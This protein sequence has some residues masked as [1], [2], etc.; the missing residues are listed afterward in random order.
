MYLD[1]VI[2]KVARLGLVVYESKEGNLLNIVRPSSVAGSKFIGWESDTVMGVGEITLMANAPCAVL[3]VTG[4]G[5][6]ERFHLNISI[7]AAPGPGPEWFDETFKTGDEVVEAIRGC[8][9]GDLI[10]SENESLQKFFG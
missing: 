7:L 9:F 3:T 1:S 4:K 6:K 2:S 8:Y 5:R 10:D